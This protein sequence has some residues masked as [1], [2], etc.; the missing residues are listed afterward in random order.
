MNK[1]ESIINISK[2]ILKF[3]SSVDSIKKDGK[4]NYGKFATL[5]NMLEV[6]QP[7]LNSLGLIVMQHPSGDG[8]S[9]KLETVIIHAETGEFVSSDFAM[10][11][12][13]KDPQGIGSCITYMRR[14]AL[15]AI[16]VLNVGDD[17]DGDAASQKQTMKQSREPYIPP[18]ALTLDELKIL[19]ANIEAIN[20]IKSHI[21]YAQTLE[22]LHQIGKEIAFIEKTDAQRAELAKA[23]KERMEYIKGGEG[24]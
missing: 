14:Y 1:S 19:N 21:S 11:P 4:A 17:D 18:E 6:I 7:V 22:D 8:Q 12:V 2:A 20:S 3:Q 15:G 24:V 16:L 23:Y 9:I 5:S 13:K 10:I